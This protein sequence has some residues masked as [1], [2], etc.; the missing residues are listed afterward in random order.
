[1]ELNGERLDSI[2]ITSKSDGRIVTAEDG[3]EVIAIISDGEII[4]KHGFDVKVV[5]VSD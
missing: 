4:V 3:Q 2:V 5:P 1:M